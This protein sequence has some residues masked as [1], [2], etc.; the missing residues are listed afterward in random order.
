MAV[1]SLLFAMVSLLFAML[2]LLHVHYPSVDAFE[3]LMLLLLLLLR[4]CV[5]WRY[6]VWWG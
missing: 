1:I 6:A 4:K 5:V 2:L 3:V